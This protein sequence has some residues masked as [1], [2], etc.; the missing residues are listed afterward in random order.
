MNIASLVSTIAVFLW[1]GFVVVLILVVVAAWRGRPI[2]KGSLIILVIGAVAIATSLLSAG[3]VWV[4]PEERGMVV[5]ALQPEGYRPEALNPGLHFIVPFAENVI[6][7][8]ISKQTYTMSIAPNEGQLS[9]DDSISARTS[10]GQEVMV[11]ASVIYQIDPSKVTQIA[12]QWQNRY[13]D[14]LVRPVSRG[15]IRDSISQFS[16]QE[17]YSTKRAEV[18]EIITTSLKEQ[19]DLNGLQLIDFVLRNIQF[20]PEYAA[21]V[22]QKQIAEQ[23]AQQAAFVVQQKQQ[24][25]QQAREV[26]KGQA[27]AAVTVAEGNAKSRIINADAEAKALATIQAALQGHPELL[28]YQYITKLAPNIQAML[29]PSNSPFIMNLPNMGL[30]GQTGQ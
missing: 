5:S 30:T 11:D 9:G 12:I 20:S 14:D 2:K 3:L 1:V 6:L 22:E 27:D 16:V 15:V 19:M 10:D 26:A 25:A 21:S 23:Q 7:Y 24:E 18:S 29:L 17:V 8:P 4:N 28:T 13:S